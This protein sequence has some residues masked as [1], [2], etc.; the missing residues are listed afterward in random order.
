MAV[1]D[2]AAREEFYG[3]I[4][5]HSLKPLW[6]VL[7]GQLTPEPNPPEAAVL[8]HYDEVRPFLLEAARLISV[9]EADRRVLVLENPALPGKTRATQS[10]YAGLQI[11]MPGEVAPCHRHTPTALRLMVEGEGAYTAVDGERT[12]M[13]PGDFVITRSW[14]WHDHG[15]EG[16]GPAVWLDGLDFPLVGFLN[17]TFFQGYGEAAYPATRLQG[18]SQARY[19]SGIL[20]VDYE[21]GGASTPLLN[22]PYEK[23][24]EALAAL[25]HAGDCDP[26]HGVKARYTNPATG[27]YAMP[28]MGA[29]VQLL[30][31]A[32]RGLPHR[33]TD[34]TIYQ[35]IEGT[36][37][38]RIGDEL[39][40]W[41]AHDVFV[42]PSWKW[43][44]HEVDGESVLFSFSDRPVQ[45]KL[46]L[47]REQRSGH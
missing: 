41:R 8:W 34:S 24:R 26:C 2:S 28:T 5:A 4:G 36:G 9:V 3:R 6:E 10:L 35:V 32:F 21:P 12:S 47:W 37:R 39:L 18:D 22:Y 17:A 33:S 27:D 16:S 43:H 44:H 31:P 46:G 23:T 15:N 45:Q 13:R 19:G 30:G 20:P 42:V 11:I 7:R 38:T 29:F 14:S 40:E 1:Q 25:A